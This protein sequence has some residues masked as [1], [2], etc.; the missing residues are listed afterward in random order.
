MT[1]RA[2]TPPGARPDLRLLA[3][4][5]PAGEAVQGAQPGVVARRAPPGG[6]SPAAWARGATLPRSPHAA[7]PGEPAARLLAGPP[8]AAGA[9]PLVE[10]CRRLGPLPITT[11]RTAPGERALLLAA[12][13]ASGLRGR[14]GGEFP[15]S[16][17][18]ETAAAA[19][20]AGEAPI[21]VVNGSE[22]EP[23][24]RKDRVLLE[25]RPHLVLDGATL[26]AA[27]CGAERVVC[28]LHPERLRS[29]HTLQR[30]VEERRI[31]G[32][33]EPPIV[34]A[35]APGGY[36]GGESGAVVDGLEGGP[37]LPSRRDLPVAASGVAGRPTVVANVET[38]AHL[39]LVARF[40]AEWFAE[41]GTPPCP[42]STLVTLG[43][44]VATPGLVVELLAPV[45]GGALLA[46]LGGLD[47]APAAVLVG[48]YGGRWLEGRAF[49]ASPV[50]R[51]VLR[52]AGIGLGCGLI[53]PLPER[54]CGPATTLRLLEYLAS[55]SSGQCAPC[56]YGLPALAAELE[57]L[58]EGR[59]RRRAVVRM[60]RASLSIAGHGACA[61]PDGAVALL[62]SALS[63]FAADLDAHSRRRRCP[64]VEE[65]GW[66]PLPSPQGH[67]LR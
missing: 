24:S 29:W 58:L 18:L 61:H 5:T 52:E 34:L 9:E 59:H 46:E 2:R 55:E 8:A 26:A 27:A 53:A 6:G 19:A 3:P 31:A 64:G 20:S 56:R 32:V 28:Y 36:V 10:H 57:A 37:A 12:L 47:E 14:G 1:S 40:G 41:A 17:K 30:A 63:V 62:E 44:N 23:A 49:C 4:P 39:A 51:G 7:L 33:V 66:F 67:G 16:R 48:G 35:A 43:G 11:V 13:R 42:G 15:L 60:Q 45:A 21:V 25:L 38:H 50:D 54:A 65:A 22:G